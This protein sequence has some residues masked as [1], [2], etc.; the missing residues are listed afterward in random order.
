[1]LLTYINEVSVKKL[2]VCTAGRFLFIQL[3]SLLLDYVHS[4]RMLTAFKFVTAFIKMTA[5]FQIRE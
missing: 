4:A 5:D 3:S 2:F 1:M